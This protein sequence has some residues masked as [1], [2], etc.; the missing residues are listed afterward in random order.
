[1]HVQPY[2]YCDG[3]CEGGSAF[4]RTPP[5]GPSWRG[6]ADALQRESPARDGVTRLR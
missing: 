4:Y 1:M 5:W 6:E 3:R 2:L